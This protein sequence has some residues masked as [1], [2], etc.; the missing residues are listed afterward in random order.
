MTTGRINQ[1]TIVPN[2]VPAVAATDEHAYAH[3]HDGSFVNRGLE[4]RRF[5][6]SIP[7]QVLSLAFTCAS[8]LTDDSTR[9]RRRNTLF[10]VLAHFRSLRPVPMKG[11]GW[12]PSVK[13]TKRP[14]KPK[15]LAT[16]TADLRV[17][18]CIRFGHRQA[19]HTLQHCRPTPQKGEVGLDPRNR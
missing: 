15:R 16:A 8:K 17:N 13:T 1:V 10:P 19:I 6:F 3:F 12:L 11:R 2:R 7:P 5:Q 18:S 9:T 14:A 4:S